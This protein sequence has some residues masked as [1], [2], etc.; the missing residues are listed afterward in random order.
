MNRT[1][2]K[3]TIK[4]GIV[5]NLDKTKGALIWTKQWHNWQLFIT[6]LFLAGDTREIIL[7]RMGRI[8]VKSLI[9]FSSRIPRLFCVFP[10]EEYTRSLVSSFLLSVSPIKGQWKAPIYIRFVSG[11]QRSRYNF[12]LRIFELSPG[13]LQVIIWPLLKSFF[14]F[15]HLQVRNGYERY[16]CSS[17]DTVHYITECYLAKYV[18]KVSICLIEIFKKIGLFIENNLRYVQKV[19]EFS[20]KNCFLFCMWVTYW[21]R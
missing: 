14:S 18:S 4:F 16:S 19:L 10:Q 20:L 1:I 17:L 3:I 13:H 11:K 12:P 6:L 15:G 9:L 2:V 21:R 8:S 5:K 7:G